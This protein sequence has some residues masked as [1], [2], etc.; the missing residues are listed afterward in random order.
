MATTHSVT[1]T[2]KSFSSSA[3]L[4]S[5]TDIKGN[6][7]YANPDFCDIAGFELSEL[8][9]KP[10]N[11]VRH[12]DM[13]GAAFA[14][15][16]S[17][18][19]EGKSWMGP[20]KN[21]CKNGD[22]YW[23]NAY[24]TPIKDKTGKTIEY[25]SVRTSQE[26]DVIDRAEVLYQQLN[27]GKTPKALT[28][29]NVDIT[30][31]VQCLLALLTLT[32]IASAVVTAMPMILAIA[33]I[34]LSLGTLALFSSWRTRYTKLVS[35]AEQVFDNP[36][37]S[38]LYSGRLDKL[39]RIELA[40]KMRKAELNAIVGRVKDLSGNV[41]AIATDT[42]NNGNEISQ[43]LMEQNDEITHVAT[44]MNQMTSTIQDL[45]STVTGAAD[46]SEQ[47]KVLTESGMAIVEKTISSI[48]TL[49]SQ[50]QSV[51]AVIHKLVDGSRS[52]ET[53]SNEISSIADQTNLLA[54]N[55]AIEAARAGEQGRGFAVVA[56]EVRALAQRTQQSTLQIR[57]TLEQL[58]QESNDAINE[59]RKGVE[60]ADQCVT[61]ANDT[62]KS[63]HG[64]NQEVD[65]IS[66]LNQQIATA[67]EQ[68]T[69]VT[70]QVNQNTQ[71]ISSITTTGIAHGQE[72]KQLSATLL[73]ELQSLHS[74]VLQFRC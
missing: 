3:I 29:T 45:A 11:I 14:N 26:P 65:K 33:A 19:E 64:V 2:E 68:Q 13:P 49:S 34:G 28:Q 40:L 51:D 17:T 70:D 56:D 18:I 30:F 22:H 54:L 6:V 59:M 39:G 10:H 58:N 47:G 1:G 15:L 36:L 60:L 4:L 53:I 21:R 73:T 43:M 62:G 50:L 35:E 24:V 38:F 8:T 55:A 16:W 20:V 12:P 7:T 61:L 32:L 57:T 74:L 69:V 41:S 67:V 23:V 37:M 31:Y 46:A 52:I 48:H 27:Q 5:T 63:L 9:G 42:A 71:R 25:Q 44:A 72:S 66:S